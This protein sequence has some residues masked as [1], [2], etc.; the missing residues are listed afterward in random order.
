MA[1]VSQS[2]GSP[3]AAPGT[4]PAALREDRGVPA[5][6]EPALAP[7]LHALLEREPLFHRRACVAN[8]AD[9]E[10][11]TSDDFWEVGASGRRYD[12]E[13]V[14]SVLANRLA[15]P[16]DSGWHISDGQV[17]QAGTD[18]YLLTY[19]LG[20]ARARVTRR[21]TVWRGSVVEGWTALYHQGTVVS[22]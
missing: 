8:R 21:L 20:D 4:A 14:W 17:R 6:T 18:V 13:S 7:V 22:D 16:A 19:T 12:R 1:S 15:E 3:S 2:D 10:R 5:S 9:F 11:E